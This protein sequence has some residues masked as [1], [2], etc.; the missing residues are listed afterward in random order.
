[1][2]TAVSA[3]LLQALAVQAIRIIQSNDDGW[4]E[5]YTRSFFS[6]LTSA[7]NTVC[8]SAPADN[9]SG[10]GGLDI[11]PEPR[12]SACQYDSCPANSGATG[13]N[14]TQPE[15]NWVNSFPAT[16]MRYGRTKICPAL[17]NGAAPELA[18]A[19]PNVGSNLFA[20]VHF[21]GTVGAACDA[22]NAGI[23]AIAFSGATEDRVA[24]NTVPV[25]HSGE[26]YAELATTI[27]SKIIASGTPYLPEG[28][29]LNVNF[30]Q[31]TDECNA[32]SDFK[33]VLS[34]INPGI[35]SPPDVE[36]CGSTR[37]PQE[38][39]VINAGGC[40]VSISI[41]DSKDKTTANDDRQDAVLAKLKD[42]LTCL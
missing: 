42:I 35:L 18:V 40:R 14:A 21:S 3:V 28:I 6:S 16:S 34:R 41:G 24:W 20:A 23:P 22:A 5:S 11:D 8:L 13:S 36:Q 33:F 38:L 30:P 25:P 17:W 4:A 10:T 26:V 32:A 2:K 7:G 9:K 37:L 12:S 19:G 39:E 15:L 31:V 29:W 1:M 27:T